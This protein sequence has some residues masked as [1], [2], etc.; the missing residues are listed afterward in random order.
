[1]TF[2]LRV[3]K[4]VLNLR[5]ISSIAIFPDGAEVYVG[6]RVVE[7]DR[8]EATALMKQLANPLAVTPAVNG[9]HPLWYFSTVNAPRP[10]QG[11][12]PPAAPTP[13]DK[14]GAPDPNAATERQL[15]YLYDVGKRQN[16]SPEQ[17]DGLC[18]SSFRGRRPSGLSKQECGTLIDQIKEMALR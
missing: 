7:V 16:L 15:A 11:T 4:N 12:P 9:A 14:P 2:F 8:D 13:P 3:G 1:M 18:A 6:P 5:D 17:V 10:A